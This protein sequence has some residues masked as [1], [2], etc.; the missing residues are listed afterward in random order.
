MIKK[1][2]CQI[3]IL[4]FGC[5]LSALRVL[6]NEFAAKSDQPFYLSNG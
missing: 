2:F 1:L 4:P 5:G 6:N 3:I